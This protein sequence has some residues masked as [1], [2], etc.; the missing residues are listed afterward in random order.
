MRVQMHTEGISDGKALLAHPKAPDVTTIHRPQQ[1]LFTNKHGS[2]F[3]M[4]LW[5]IT[6]YK[7]ESEGWP[8]PQD[9]QVQICIMTKAVA[10]LPF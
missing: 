3:S 1:L 9:S 7:T 4:E 8:G 10:T 2:F 6:G 5:R